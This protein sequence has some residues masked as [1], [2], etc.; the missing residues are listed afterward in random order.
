MKQFRGPHARAR[1]IQ[2]PS[3]WKLTKAEARVVERLAQGRRTMEIATDLGLSVHTIRTQLKRAMAKTGV[4]TQAA[5]VAMF[6]SAGNRD[7]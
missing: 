3:V 7:D 6:Y 1:R 5:L 4:H 2:A